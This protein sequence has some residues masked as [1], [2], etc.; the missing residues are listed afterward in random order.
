MHQTS[1]RQGFR[2]R[3]LQRSLDVRDGVNESNPES[4]DIVFEEARGRN[5]REARLWLEKWNLKSKEKN[6]DRDHRSKADIYLQELYP[7]VQ[8]RRRKLV[9]SK[10]DSN[11]ILL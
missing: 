1:G 6:Q 11:R 10:I 8:S 9:I 3:E 7:R 2:Q 5:E 4:S